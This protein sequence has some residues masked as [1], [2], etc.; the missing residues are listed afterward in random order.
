MRLADFSDRELLLI[1]G[2]LQGNSNG[3]A[4]TRDVAV[5]VGMDNVHGLRCVGSRLSYLRRIGVLEDRTADAPQRS[6]YKL[7][8]LSDMGASL[9]K[10]ALTAAES[11]NL[12]KLTPEKLVLITQE[13]ARRSATV[14]PDSDTVKTIAWRAFRRESGRK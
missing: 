6:R 10:G 14:D 12:A 2:D 5:K 1:V 13:I 4:S 7:W 3:W 8:G 9:A 11:R